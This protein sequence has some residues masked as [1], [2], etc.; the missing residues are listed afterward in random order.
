[1]KKMIMKHRWAH[2]SMNINQIFS[3]WG[4]ARACIRYL[5]RPGHISTRWESGPRYRILEMPLHNSIYSLPN[6]AWG[7]WRLRWFLLDDL[8]KFGSDCLVCLDSLLSRMY[9]YSV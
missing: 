6:E 7:K 3:F 8:S 4:W 2:S 9:V 5:Q 1:M